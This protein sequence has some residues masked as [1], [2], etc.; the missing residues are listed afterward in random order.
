MHTAV[1]LKPDDPLYC[2]VL[3][4]AYLCED[5]VS[6]AVG[7]YINAGIL[8][9]YDTVNLHLIR[10]TMEEKYSDAASRIERK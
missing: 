3:A 1:S 6:E 10:K 8:D 2:S 5:L 4:D 7:C 9:D